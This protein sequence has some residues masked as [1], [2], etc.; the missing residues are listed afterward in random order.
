MSTI[1]RMSLPG[2]TYHSPLVNADRM[3]NPPIKIN[4]VPIVPSVLP[5]YVKEITPDVQLKFL[6]CEEVNSDFRD[7]LLT[8]FKSV[9]PHINKAIIL[10]KDPIPQD[11]QELPVTQQ[12]IR[13]LI[14]VYNL[15]ITYNPPPI[16]GTK[17][18]I[19][20]IR[21]LID[22]VNFLDCITPSNI[23]EIINHTEDIYNLTVNVE[24]NM[25]KAQRKAAGPPVEFTLK[26][27]A[28]GRRR[29]R[30]VTRKPKIRRNYN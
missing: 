21:P 24:Q 13:T 10:L 12:L 29:K 27:Q 1:G 9:I 22:Y 28:A 25:K 15:L 16:Q 26:T 2:F 5:A 17:T 20:N 8:V 7:Y 19:D 11:V 30:R 23:D 14:H 4:Y 6:Q 3:Q 18:W